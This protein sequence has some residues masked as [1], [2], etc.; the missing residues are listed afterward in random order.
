MAPSKSNPQSQDPLIIVL[1]ATG[2]GKSS[3]LYLLTGDEGCRGGDTLE[4]DTAEIK[5]FSYNDSKGLLVKL[6]DTPGFDDSREGVTDAD[7][8]EQLSEFLKDKFKSDTHL[9]GL[10]YVHP[11]TA[12][13]VNKT[14]KQNFRLFDKF[15]G[16]EALKNAVIVTTRWDC[17]DGERPGTG[18]KREKELREKDGL[19]KHLVSGG[20]QM[21]RHYNTPDSA[22][23]IMSL[24]LDNKPIDPAFVKE[25]N[26]G[27]PV[28]DTGAGKVMNERLDEL[29]QKQE[30]A[31]NDL[32]EEIAAIKNDDQQRKDLEKERSDL[33]DR[34]KQLE[35]EKLKL[36]K[37]P[38]DVPPLKPVGIKVSLNGI[39]F[40]GSGYGDFIN[41]SV[42]V[43]IINTS[44][45]DIDFSGDIDVVYRF[46]KIGRVSLERV[47]LRSGNNNF[48]ALQWEFEPGHSANVDVKSFFDSY[49]VTKAILPLSLRID[50]PNMRCGD[51]SKSPLQSGIK[52]IESRLVHQV[53]VFLGVGAIFN[54]VSFEFTF[55]N[56]L[57]APLV[58]REFELYVEIAGTRIAWAS[59][60]KPFTMP[61]KG[62]KWSE[63]A[64]ARL[65]NNYFT[66][67]RHGLNPFATLDIIEVVSA[68]ITIGGYDI[69]NL[70]FNF[71]KVPYSLGATLW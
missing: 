63:K 44:S 3:F 49:F 55:E 60:S 40:L 27:R 33:W 31:M 11:I 47:N 66:S 56:P 62:S 37:P 14:V 20:A 68:N 5:L 70:Q 43:N 67:A 57:D 61:A 46:T 7:L 71:K 30:K 36:S 35:A 29:V 52:G 42:A 21:A 4:S 32:R 59:V 69:D 6:A 64:S 13:R 26:E 9:T 38:T 23:A 50:S 22:H 24:L 54:S 51:L 2:A 34:I 58:I 65:L 15:C 25:V 16:A 39:K 8:L 17:L 10:I 1:G 48:P 41:A 53:K 12:V 28:G 45:S 18:E 19:F